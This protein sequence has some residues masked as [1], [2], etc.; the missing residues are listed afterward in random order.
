MLVGGLSLHEPCTDD[1]QCTGTENAQT[2]S[3][4]KGETQSICRCNDG[5][6]E[7][8]SACY[9]GNENIN[10]PKLCPNEELSFMEK[11]V[12]NIIHV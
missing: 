3:A 10:T 11:E 6:I 1:Q 8:N 5:Y 7:I 2:C 12:Y 9:R 4:I